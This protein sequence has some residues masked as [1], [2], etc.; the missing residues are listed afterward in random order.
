MGEKEDPIFSKNAEG[1]GNTRGMEPRC[2][3]WLHPSS[4][5]SPPCASVSLA[6]NRD[7]D[8]TPPR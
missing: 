1:D 8:N 6:A 3:L 7:N 4:A 2:S 5:T